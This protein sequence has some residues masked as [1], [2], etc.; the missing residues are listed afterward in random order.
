MYNDI[1]L[2]ELAHNIEVT[3]FARPACLYLDTSV[4][5]TVPL[6]ATGWGRTDFDGPSSA[7]LLEVTLEQFSTGE[8]GQTYKASKQLPGGVNGDSQLC[9]GSKYEKKDTCKGDSGGPLQV[10]QEHMDCM[11][12]VV[13][14]TSF[15]RGCGNIGVP[16]VY[17][18][19]SHFADWIEERAFINE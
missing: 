15:G 13:G 5:P 2:L 10:K 1:G 8:C 3:Q 9:A 7:D 14:V 4:L 18:R 16:G 17:T 12:S 6:I 19:V 11:Y